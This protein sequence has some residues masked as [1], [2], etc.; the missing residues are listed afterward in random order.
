MLKIAIVGTGNLAFHLARQLQL[1]GNEPV[2]I[3]SRL[4]SRSEKLIDDLSLTSK[5]VELKD[6]RRLTCDLI[7]LA[8]PDRAIGPV[9]TSHLLPQNTIV[10]HTSGSQPMSILD[11]T[12]RH[13]VIYPLQTFR[14][15]K[16][17]DFTQVLFYM[18][19]NNAETLSQLL[20][21]DK[22][23]P[24]TMK[25]MSSGERLKVHLAAVFASNFTNHLY[26]IAEKIL[27]ET[28]V[29]FADLRH[30]IAETT[31]KAL[32]MPPEQAQT[33]P[34]IRGDVEII[35]QHLK[36]LE[37]QPEWQKIYRLISE[38]ISNLRNT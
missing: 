3:V 18:E 36:L 14:K 30:L 28:G 26:V 11:P 16:P 38:Q 4:L 19:A 20:S 22:Y 27:S 31:Q 37:T 8:I 9:M 1:K 5:P 12:P 34:A 10:V 21:L 2:A 13:G 7:I 17:V 29:E 32:T 23:F 33:G 6:C 24:G 35:E 25:V 15:E